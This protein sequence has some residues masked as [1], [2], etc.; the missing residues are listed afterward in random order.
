MS[1]SPTRTAINTIHITSMHM[2]SP[3]MGGSPIPTSTATTPS[4]TP[5]HT[6]RISIT[7]T[8]IERGA[9]ALEAKSDQCLD[10]LVDERIEGQHNYWHDQRERREHLADGPRGELRRCQQLADAPFHIVHCD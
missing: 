8:G 9:A 6:T 7:A 1:C 10:E 5:I 4:P 3:G 2:P